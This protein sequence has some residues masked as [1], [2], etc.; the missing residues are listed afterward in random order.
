MQL[1]NL[2]DAFLNAALQARLMMEAPMLHQDD[3]DLW[4]ATDHARLERTWIAFLYVL[5]ES[6]RSQAMALVR[7][8]VGAVADTSGLDRLLDEG[9]RS[10]DIQKMRET[11][12]YMCHRDR[13][14]YWDAGRLAVMGQ[15]P[16]HSRLHQEFSQVLLVAISA[17]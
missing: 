10:G 17:T 9:E 2:H 13:R 1:A 7:A 3:P 14:R 6:W 16:F 15:L 8:H 5:V 12:D 4:F 11:R